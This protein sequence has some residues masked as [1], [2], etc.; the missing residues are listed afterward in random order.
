MVEA[1]FERSRDYFKQLRKNFRFFLYREK[2]KVG[3]NF[4]VDVVISIGL[5]SPVHDG[6]RN[7]LK[8]CHYH[9][10]A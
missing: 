9:V 6:L 10:F 5:H 4:P 1:M 3:V 8:D 2:P 7:A